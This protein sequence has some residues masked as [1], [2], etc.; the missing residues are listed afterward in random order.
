M[1]IIKYVCCFNV[2]ILNKMIERMQLFHNKSHIL[3]KS[4]EKRKKNIKNSCEDYSLK[5]IWSYMLPKGYKAGIFEGEIL[6]YEAGKT[7]R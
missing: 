7:E 4:K 1:K 5:P 6:P 3:M 2:K